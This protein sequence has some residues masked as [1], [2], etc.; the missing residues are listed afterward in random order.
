M[1]TTL[2]TI[3]TRCIVG[4]M[5]TREKARGAAIFAVM[6]I[7]AALVATGCGGGSSGSAATA[8]TA[9]RT[10]TTTTSS[11]T[12]DA[13]AQFLKPGETNPTV[14]FGKEAPAGEREEASKVVAMSLKA[15]EAA[16]FESQCRTLSVKAIQAVPGGKNRSICPAALK[17]LATPLSETVKARKDTLSGPIDAMRVKSKEGFALWHG[18]DGKDYSVPLEEENGT[19]KVASILT[20]EI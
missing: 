2:Y 18:N 9:A 19:W 7:V 10:G 16:A 3:R 17:K 20:A 1:L 13:K 12:G 6:L 8:A 15:R 5:K 14:E 4:G 11:T